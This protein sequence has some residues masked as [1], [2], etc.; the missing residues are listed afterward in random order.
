MQLMAERGLEHEI[1][2]GFGWIAA[3]IAEMEAAGLR[4]PQMGWNALDFVP[5]HHKLLDGLARAT[6]ST[7]ST[8][9][10]WSAAIRG[11]QSR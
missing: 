4:L 3:E 9:T 6:T 11:K 2:P 7:S 1:T 5:G 8:A 10:P